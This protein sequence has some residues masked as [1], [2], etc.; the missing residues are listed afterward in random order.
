[1][2]KPD[3]KKDAVDPL[4]HEGIPGLSDMFSKKKEGGGH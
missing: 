4:A 3:D 1:V 2:A